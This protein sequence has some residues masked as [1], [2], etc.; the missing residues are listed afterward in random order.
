MDLASQIEGRRGFV[1]F[2]FLGATVV[3][4]GISWVCLAPKDNVLVGTCSC[5][6]GTIITYTAEASSRPAA[7]SPTRLLAHLENIGSVQEKPPTLVCLGDSLTHGAVSANWVHVIRRTFSSTNSKALFEADANLWVVNAGQNNICSWTVSQEHLD[8]ALICNP[9]FVILWI[10]TNDLRSI[11]KK[12]WSWQM[13]HMWNLP[14]DP[15]LDGLEQNVR[16]M[17]QRLLDRSPKVKHIALCTLPPMGED[18]T[19]PANRIVKA[20]NAR[21]EKVAA[22]INM[23]SRISVLP[24]YEELETIIKENAS[25]RRWYLSVDYFLLVSPVMAM[26]YYIFGCSWNWIGRCVGNVVTTDSLHLNEKGRDVVAK[27]VRSWLLQ[28]GVQKYSTKES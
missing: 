10:G 25:P 7:S 17:L 23:S 22:D 13:V 26:L 8:R 24:V 21:L 19:H 5:I 11:Y 20:A 28:K 15:S 16:T 12:M 27:L 2:L 1:S 3:V 18:L 14:E 4:F 9:E 6:L